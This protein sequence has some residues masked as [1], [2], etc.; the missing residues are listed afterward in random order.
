MVGLK[1]L[2]P[3]SRPR[4][5]LTTT[6]HAACSSVSNVA[7]FEFSEGFPRRTKKAYAWEGGGGRQGEVCSERAAAAVAV[8]TMVGGMLDAFPHG[9]SQLA[10]PFVFPLRA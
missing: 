4:A 5:H 2:G 8:A 3:P 9:N 6:E 10:T 1:I 7:H